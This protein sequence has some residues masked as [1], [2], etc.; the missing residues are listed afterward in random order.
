MVPMGDWAATRLKS[1][2]KNDSVR[3]DSQVGSGFGKNIANWLGRNKAYPNNVLHFATEC[4]NKNHSAAFPSALPE[5][6]IKLL[7][8][9]GDMVLDPFVGSGTTLV[10][11]KGLG[12]NSVGIDLLPEYCAMAQEAVGQQELFVSEQSQSSYDKNSTAKNNEIHRKR[13]P[14]LSRKTA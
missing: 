7:T 2:G 6:F 14:R 10:A 12:R 13:N 9:K 8:D 11:S 4:G 1:L 5:W 3:Y